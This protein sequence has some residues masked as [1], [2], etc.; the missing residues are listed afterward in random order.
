[1]FRGA[2]LGPGDVEGGEWS[3][4]DAY[5][6]LLEQYGGAPGEREDLAIQA[7]GNNPDIQ[8][9]GGTPYDLFLNPR[10]IFLGF[11]LEFK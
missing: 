4:R 3:A 6:R 5:V 8:G 10:Q 11:R 1:M 9:P 2:F 7:I